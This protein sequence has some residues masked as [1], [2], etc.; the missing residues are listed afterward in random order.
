M[1]EARNDMEGTGQPD[2]KYRRE[3]IR[4][5]MRREKNVGRMQEVK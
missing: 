4:D 2:G 3:K 5:E 1:Q